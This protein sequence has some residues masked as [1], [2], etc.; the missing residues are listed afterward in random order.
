MCI[1][2]REYSRDEAENPLPSIPEPLPPENPVDA[3]PEPINPAHDPQPV[4]TKE[5]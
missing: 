2:D 1:R 4:I 5:P 3:H